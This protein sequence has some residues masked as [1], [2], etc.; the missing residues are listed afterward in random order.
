MGMVTRLQAGRSGLRLP[1]VAGDFSVLPN[2]QTGTGPTHPPIW[3]VQEFPPGIKR[4]VREVDHSPSSSGEDK[5]A[6]RYTSS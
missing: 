2:V 1:V 3:W 4:R 5:N 6:W